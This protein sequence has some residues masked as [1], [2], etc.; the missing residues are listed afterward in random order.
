MNINDNNNDNNDNDLYLFDHKTYI[1]FTI[2][3][4]DNNSG[5]RDFH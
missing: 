1:L 3:I 5:R 2:F 4:V